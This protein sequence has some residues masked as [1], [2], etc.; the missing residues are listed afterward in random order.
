MQASAAC[1]PF[2]EGFALAEAAL[3][4]M[5]DR[6]RRESFSALAHFRSPR[7]LEWIES[8]A[9]EPMVEAWGYLAAASGFSWPKATQWFEAGRPLSLIAIDALLEIAEPRTPVLRHH[10]PSIGA[11]ASPSDIRRVLEAAAS[12]DPVPRVKQRIDSLLTKLP[13]LAQHAQN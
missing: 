4:A 6:V 10:R 12:A 9:A 11:P 1:L 5:P 8:N 13:A 3:A 2:E 7:A